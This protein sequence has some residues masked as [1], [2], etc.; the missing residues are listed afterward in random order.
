MELWFWGKGSIQGW[1]A[2]WE[3]AVPWGA[4]GPQG[5]EFRMAGLS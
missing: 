3:V 2:G 5:T 4:M 1:L